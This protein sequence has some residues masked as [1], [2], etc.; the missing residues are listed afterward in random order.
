MRRLVILA[1]TKLLGTLLFLSGLYLILISL[2]SGNI[3]DRP[4]LVGY[5]ITIGG[6]IL[7]GLGAAIFG[8]SPKKKQP[9]ATSV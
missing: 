9:E 3:P 8:Y 2:A 6:W 5:S 4:V 1:I 7:A